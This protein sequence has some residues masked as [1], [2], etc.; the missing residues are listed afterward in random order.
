M[1]SERLPGSPRCSGRALG[2]TSI[3]DLRAEMQKEIGELTDRL[4]RVETLIRT[5]LVPRSAVPP[6]AG[7]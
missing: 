5:H 6:A 2:F 3:G 1:S 7:P 4:T